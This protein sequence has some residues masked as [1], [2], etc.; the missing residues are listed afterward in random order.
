MNRRD[1]LRSTVSAGVAAALPGS[2]AA[3]QHSLTTVSSSVVG[4]S[5]DGQELTL[6]KAALEEL[7]GALRGKLFLAGSDGYDASRRVLNPSA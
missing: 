3:L 4:R 5:A 1:F 2:V 7:K 6:E